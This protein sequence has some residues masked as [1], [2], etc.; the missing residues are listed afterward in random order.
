M[1]SESELQLLEAIYASGSSGQANSQR[2]LAGQA[3][4]SLGMTN[5]LLSRFAER[6]WVKLT[7]ISGRSLRYILTPSG[8]EEV[9]RRT[10]AY[11]SRAERSATNY[12][13]RIDDYVHGIARKGF[14][15]LVYEGPKELEFLF[16]YSCERR[17][18]ALV[19]SPSEELR[20]TLSQDSTAMFVSAGEPAVGAPDGSGSPGVPGASGAPLA[21]RASA[22]ALADILFPGM[23]RVR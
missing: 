13:A 4:L 19:A 14:R 12:R 3:G 21:L 18:V 11:F 10:M 15:V 2:V 6:G 20:S 1:T 9:L 5:A 7:H 22:E 17:G 16:D 23:L 8:V